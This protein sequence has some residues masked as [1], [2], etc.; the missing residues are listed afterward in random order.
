MFLGNFVLI[1]LC[2]GF[3]EKSAINKYA[4][5][6]RVA[7]WAGYGNNAQNVTRYKQ[8]FMLSLNSHPI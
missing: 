6:G 1:L 8:Q 5:I 2:I 3:L 4:S 7:H